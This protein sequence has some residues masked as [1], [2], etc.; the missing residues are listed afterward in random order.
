MILH[1]YR[2]LT[3]LPSQ[4]QVQSYEAEIQASHQKERQE[5]NAEL[6]KLQAKLEEQKQRAQAAEEK[7][8]KERSKRKRAEECT[9]DLKR[10]VEEGDNT[11]QELRH[12]IERLQK[13]AEQRRADNLRWYRRG[14]SHD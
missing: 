8:M 9:G 5:Y 14:V 3:I 4:D 13:E 12:T 11:V 1:S 2:P 7:A 10:K 6:K